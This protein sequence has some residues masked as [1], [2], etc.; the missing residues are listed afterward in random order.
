MGKKDKYF[1]GEFYLQVKSVKN[2][3]ALYDEQINCQ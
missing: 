3:R 1:E 2:Y